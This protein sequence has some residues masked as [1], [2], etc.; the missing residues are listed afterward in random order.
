MVID[1]VLVA[2]EA[3]ARMQH[4]RMLVGDPCELV[5]PAARKGAEPIEM[6]LQPPEIVRFQIKRQQVAQ[7][8]IDGVEILARAIRRDV[9]CAAFAA[10]SVL[11]I[12]QRSMR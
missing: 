10:A 12:T 5:E 3:V 7:A 1:P 9:I 6:R 4:R 11:R 2:A 8:P